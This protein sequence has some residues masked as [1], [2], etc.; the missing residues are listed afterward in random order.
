MFYV[1]FADGFEE[2][3]A[4]APVDILKRGGVEVLTA[5]VYS[6]DVCGAHGI[7]YFTDITI[8]EVELTELDGVILPGGIPG[9]PN[10]DK[11][12]KLH[13]I[14]DFAFNN[15]RLICAICAAPSILG[16]AGFL[17]GK[18]ATC[19]PGFEKSFKGGI[20]TGS[21]TEKDGNIIT[22][23]GAGAALDFAFEILAEVRGEE[24][25]SEVRK[26]MLA[27]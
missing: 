27:D 8:D 6:R 14:L 19:Y 24:K 1:F 12:E 9:T 2:L 20:Y 3:E 21:K 22:G 13:N 5:G 7:R 16:K 10:L 23:A 17:Y 4:T 26:S 25:A 15:N 18:K 11:S